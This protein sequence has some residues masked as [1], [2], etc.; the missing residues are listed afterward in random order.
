MVITLTLAITF[1]TLLF[2]LYRNLTHSAIIT[3]VQPTG[4]SEKERNLAVLA[5]FCQR[6]LKDIKKVLGFRKVF[7]KK[8]VKQS[9][10]SMK[11]YSELKSSY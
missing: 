2:I 5:S 4:E 11:L 9:H 3:N 6:T 10:Q 8:I 1:A 7:V